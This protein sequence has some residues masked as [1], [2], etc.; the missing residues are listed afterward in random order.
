MDV[1]GSI[2]GSDLPA[3]IVTYKAKPFHFAPEPPDDAVILRTYAE[4]VEKG[5]DGLGGGELD[6]YIRTTGPLPVELVKAELVAD[7]IPA[8]NP[9]DW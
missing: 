1:T 2:E 5:F 7:R 4:A 8:G 9:R 6:H 3:R